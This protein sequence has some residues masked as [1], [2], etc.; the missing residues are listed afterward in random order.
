MLMIGYLSCLQGCYDIGLPSG[1]SLFQLQAERILKLQTLA[2]AAL[3]R[4]SCAPAA[5]TAA[6]DDCCTATAQL[7][8]TI[9]WYIMTSPATHEATMQFFHSM[10]YFG[11]QQEQIVFFQQGML[12][13][14]TPEGGVIY[15]TDGQVRVCSFNM[16]CQ[17]DQSDQSAASTVKY[18]TV[19]LLL[20]GS[21]A[22]G[23][24]GLHHIC[25]RNVPVL[26][27]ALLEH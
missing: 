17:L 5:A 10:Y 8:F 19:L 20:P 14:L 16:C 23:L 4:N 27:S 2:G 3:D 1:K 7:P 21:S 11:L 15:A 6:I 25:N 22:W 24:D 26:Y 9:R 12:P 13:C 18:K